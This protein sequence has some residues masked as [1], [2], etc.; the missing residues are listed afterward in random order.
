[1]MVGVVALMSRPHH[2]W[3][4]VAV[5]AIDFHVDIVSVDAYDDEDELMGGSVL[6]MIRNSKDGL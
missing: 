4:I 3:M 1:M 6:N 2:S 5:R